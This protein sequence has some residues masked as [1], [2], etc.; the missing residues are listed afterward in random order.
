MATMSAEMVK[1]RGC[2]HQ[3]PLSAH[4]VC[5]CAQ[6]HQTFA[7]EAAALRHQDVSYTRRKPYVRCRTPAEAGLVDGARTYAGKPYL[8]LVPA[9][10][11]P[12]L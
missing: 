8:C 6:C 5:H 3:W 12:T 4:N 11:T 9:T 1:C 7:D 2:H 10:E